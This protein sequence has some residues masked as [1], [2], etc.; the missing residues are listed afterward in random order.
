MK[1]IFYILVFLIIS[2]NSYAI[3]SCATISPLYGILAYI[4]KNTE[5][6]TLILNKTDSDLHSYALTPS[7]A[8]KIKKCDIIFMIDDNFE[9]F[10]DK[11]TKLS[12][13]KSRIIRV[14]E[15]PNIKL[16]ELR[17]NNVFEEEDA[18]DHDHGFYDYHVW[19]DIDNTKAIAEMITNILSKEEKINEKIYQANLNKFIIKLD[20]LDKNLKEQLSKINK[21]PYIVFH[22]AYQYLE[23]KYGLKSVGAIIVNEESNLSADSLAS[24]KELVAEN[25][26]KCI[27][28]EP[29]FPTKIID[30]I[31][32][33]SKVRHGMLNAEWANAD[34]P[35]DIYFVIMES[36]MTSLV[37]CLK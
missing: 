10:S 25:K 29:Q 3:N 9:S 19:L 32:E 14:S 5:H 20:K 12:K 13:K 11:L 26:V 21:Q 4:T 15:A 35:E 17:E 2:N 24:I 22:D 18:H 28:S 27:F 30:K 7:D 8:L 36:L 33:S 31:S 23:N 34:K 6:P 16:L 1:K 37:G